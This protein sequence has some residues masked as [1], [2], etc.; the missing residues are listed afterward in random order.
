MPQ[1]VPHQ[2]APSGPQRF[3]NAGD[4]HKDIGAVAFLL[5]RLEAAHLAFN[6]LNCFSTA[7]SHRPQD[8]FP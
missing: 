8:P 6:A 7:Q 3:V 5:H 1:V 4:L 2:F